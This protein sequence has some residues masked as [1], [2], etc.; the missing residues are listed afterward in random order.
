[1][2]STNSS[3]KQRIVVAVDGGIH[4]TNRGMTGGVGMI[5][6]RIRPVTPKST[7]ILVESIS[8][9]GR[10]F[11][12]STKVTNNIMEL[13]GFCIMAHAL[14][15]EIYVAQ[16]KE[17]DPDVGSIEFW[18]DSQYA[19]GILFRPK[20]RAKE[21]KTLVKNT[22]KELD[23]IAAVVPVSGKFIRGHKGHFINE[24]ADLVAALCIQRKKDITHEL[25]YRDIE[26]FCLF[27]DLFPCQQ[28]ESGFGCEP[29]KKWGDRF[30]AIRKRSYTPPCANRK[31]YD[32]EFTLRKT[33]V[34]QPATGGSGARN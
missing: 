13:Q 24:F 28:P 19:L 3:P 34:G 11:D 2:P 23:E 9:R 4:K 12:A 22:K 18:S 7:R 17:V 5:T 29:I 26:D 1:M 30:E 6:F 10:Y 16:K 14:N 15:D 27:C 20:W 33:P 21:N 25:S 31:E 8:V 32:A